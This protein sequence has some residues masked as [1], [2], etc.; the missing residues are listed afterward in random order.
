MFTRISAWLMFLKE[1][2]PME[3]RKFSALS[4]DKSLFF[5]KQAGNNYS[6]VV[7]NFPFKI[8]H[9]LE[10]GH[11]LMANWFDDTGKFGKTIINL[12]KS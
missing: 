1:S 3:C 12:Y 5:S 2:F 9:S 11:S 6:G 7:M 10:R 8:I 4:F